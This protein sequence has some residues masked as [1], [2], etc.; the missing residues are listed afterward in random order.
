MTGFSTRSIAA[1]HPGVVGDLLHEQLVVVASEEAVRVVH[2][3]G[4]ADPPVRRVEP[5]L[6]VVAGEHEAGALE[7]VL[8]VLALE[9]AHVP[10]GDVVVVAVE[11]P[12]DALGQ[13]GR[14]RDRDASARAQHPDELAHRPLGRPQ[15]LEHLRGDDDV[16]RVVGERQVQRVAVDRAP[17]RSPA[18]ISSATPIAPMTPR[19]SLSSP[20]E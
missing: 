5:V 10:A 9:D 17:L 16:E 19:T 18:G 1:S 11:P 12:A 8:E 6:V 14:H 7:P 2:A 15:V 3:A 13:L 4:A 20:S